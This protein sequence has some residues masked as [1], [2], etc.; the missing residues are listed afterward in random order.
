M[1][2]HNAIYIYTYIF[3]FRF[4]S[5]GVILTLGIRGDSLMDM[6]KSKEKQLIEEAKEKAPP[7]KGKKTLYLDLDQFKKLTEKCRKNGV[8]VS[9]MVDI[10]IKDFVK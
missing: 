6:D 10:L 2:V 1:A 7:E 5:C 3:I 4:L 8:P 9:A